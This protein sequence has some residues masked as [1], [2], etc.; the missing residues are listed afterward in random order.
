MFRFRLK[1]FLQMGKYIAFQCKDTHS[2]LLLQQLKLILATVLLPNLLQK[3]YLLK[4]YKKIRCEKF[5]YLVND[6]QHEIFFSYIVL[7]HQDHQYT[8]H[9]LI[10]LLHCLHHCFPLDFFSNKIII[11]LVKIQ[12]SIF[13]KQR[14]C[15]QF[16][17]YK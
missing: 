9:L 6:C 17:F 16:N 5:I 14:S 8:A 2:M 12:K 4:Q 13:G 7:D 15:Y 1:I 11:K 10:F 3:K